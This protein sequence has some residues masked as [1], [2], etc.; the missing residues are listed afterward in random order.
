MI[1]L[2]TVA[3]AATELTEQPSLSAKTKR[4]YEIALE[5]FCCVLGSHY[6]KDI[7]RKEIEEYLQGKTALSWRTHNRHQTII[8]R[9]F[10]FA[11]ERGYVA[12]NPSTHIRR[13]K[14]DAS[15]S[16]HGSDEAVRY[17][18]EHELKL[19]FK[20]ASRNMRLLA[21]I[22]LLYESGARIAEVLALNKDDLNFEKREFQVVGKGN[23]KRWCYFGEQSVKTFT[24]YFEKGRHHPHEALFTD[25]YAYT[26]KLRRLS[27][28][29]AHRD[30]KE[31]IEN[32]KTLSNVH[33]HDLRHTFA[34]E[35]AKIIPLEVLRALLG[36]TSIQTTLIYQKITSSVARETAQEALEKLNNR[37]IFSVK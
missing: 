35:R 36:H 6:I 11:I 29:Q 22:T 12:H 15:K 9:L 34:T 8:T 17:L 7:T 5:Q 27:Y 21:L 18:S 2:L 33:F 23:K 4:S 3:R 10:N 32:Y 28:Q 24:L 16:E 20:V 25:R 26:N 37:S 30:L 31:A 14:P 19:L 13:K 1:P